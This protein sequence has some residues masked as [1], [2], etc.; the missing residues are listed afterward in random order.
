MIYSRNPDTSARRALEIAK[1]WP[2]L[3]L[4]LAQSVETDQP[5][6]I[7]WADAGQLQLQEQTNHWKQA[8]LP[9]GIGGIDWQSWSEYPRSR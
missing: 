6:D 7:S 2:D 5:R 9:A 3:K 4:R 8:L 1:R